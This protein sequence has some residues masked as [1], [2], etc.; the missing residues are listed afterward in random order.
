VIAALLLVPHIIGA[1]QPENLESAVPAV[2]A[3]N[4]V[5]SSLMANA[6]MWLVIGILLGHVLPQHIEQ[7]TA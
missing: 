7:K 3:S 4:F 2:L 6:V 5:S 1:P